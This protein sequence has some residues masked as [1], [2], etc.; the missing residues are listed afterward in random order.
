MISIGDCA[1][2]LGVEGQGVDS[3]GMFEKVEIVKPR[4][5]DK[6]HYDSMW[7]LGL[8]R[9]VIVGK[10]DILMSFMVSNGLDVPG[11]GRIVRSW[12]SSWSVEE[13][14][15]SFLLLSMLCG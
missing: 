8:V 14:M 3:E 6:S 13:K 9:E 7:G 5:Q 11:W 4:T 10:M 15:E 1:C 12:D 2:Q